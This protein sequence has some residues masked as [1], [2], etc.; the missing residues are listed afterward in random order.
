MAWNN[1]YWIKELKWLLANALR[2]EYAT[3]GVTIIHK[4][5]LKVYLL[6]GSLSTRIQYHQFNNFRSALLSYKLIIYKSNKKPNQYIFLTIS[7]STN[8]RSG[9]KC[10]FETSAVVPITP[11]TT[12]Y[13]TISD[14][15]NTIKYIHTDIKSF[16]DNNNTDIKSMNNPI[17]T[18]LATLIDTS[19]KTKE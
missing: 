18:M 9:P 13:Q 7:P 15:D 5:H 3:N 6:S 19:V 16:K 11:P 10:L 8:T 2:E 14:L 17:N 1:Q 4:Q 12:P